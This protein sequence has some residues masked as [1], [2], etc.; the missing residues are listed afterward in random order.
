V[1]SIPTRHGFNRIGKEAVFGVHRPDSGS[2]APA[3]AFVEDTKQIGHHQ[4]GNCEALV[5]ERFCLETYIGDI[6]FDGATTVA[7]NDGSV[8]LEAFVADGAQNAGHRGAISLAP[9]AVR[10]SGDVGI[11]S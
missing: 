2:T 5:A 7:Q 9:W 8:T 4:V 10:N 6:C 11:F 1:Y 3:I